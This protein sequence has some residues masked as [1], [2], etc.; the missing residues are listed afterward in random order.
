[1][2]A[3]YQRICLVN[4]H[5]IGLKGHNRAR[6]EM[7][8]LRNLEALLAS[9]PIVTIHRVSGRL[10]VFIEEGTPL[11]VACEVLEAIKGVPGVARV[12]CG[13]KCPR[14][15]DVIC[16]VAIE[17]LGEAD[18]FLTFKVAARRSHTDFATTSAEMNQIVGAA[19][20]AAFPDK[21]VRM[22]QPDVTVGVEVVQNAV[23]VHARSERG[24]GGLPVGSSGKV[25]ALLSS[26][27]DS[28]VALWRIARRGAACVAVHFSGRP[29]A[30][31]A[32]EFLVDD[33]ARVLER[34]GC[35]ARVYVVPF[36]DYQRQISLKVPPSMRIL[37]YRRLMFRVA[38]RIACM[39]GAG[40]LATGESLGQVASQTLENIQVT[41]AVVSLPVF[42]PLIGTD[43]QEIIAEA[44]ALGTFEI[45]SQDASDCCTLFMP[46]NPETHGS[47]QAAEDAEVGL[48]LAAWVEQIVAAAELHEY[49]CPGYRRPRR[50]AAGRRQDEESLRGVEGASETAAAFDMDVDSGQEPSEGDAPRAVGEGGQEGP[51]S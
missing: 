17:A 34:F 25:V 26:G 16:R 51:S 37:M 32:S 33:I 23:Y 5:E 19:L 7:R 28:P 9:Y 46:R 43:K 42:R 21:G 50:G 48:P 18:D 38:E 8:L 35:I 47:V 10:C 6:F 41:D 14:D 44:Q 29:Q 20:C 49:T 30:S 27:I 13:F 2:S 15:L 40:A 4:Y 31:D 45:S 36:G 12:S 3:K 1:M 11:E 22:K 39:E 24:V